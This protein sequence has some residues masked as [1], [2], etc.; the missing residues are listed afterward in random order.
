MF[1]TN[2]VLEEELKNRN[3]DRTKTNP[4]PICRSR[5]RQAE[6]SVVEKDQKET[7]KHVQ[8]SVFEHFQAL[9]KLIPQMLVY[10]FT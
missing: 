1:P 10:F 7:N 6:G 5:N 2:V 9:S 3:T 4:P 8:N